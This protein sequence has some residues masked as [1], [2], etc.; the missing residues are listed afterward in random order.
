MQNTMKAAVR[1]K[2]GALKVENIPIPSLN[3]DEVLLKIR[4]CG[5]CVA[6]ILDI[7]KERMYGHFILVA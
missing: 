7:L 1:K 3:S 5:V 2:S 4:A 6:A